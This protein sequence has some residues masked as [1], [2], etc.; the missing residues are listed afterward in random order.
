M[1]E[2]ILGIILT[3]GVISL[4]EL[5]KRS[6]FTKEEVSSTLLYLEKKGIFTFS[7]QSLSICDKCPLFKI[8]NIKDLKTKGGFYVNHLN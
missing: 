3:E 7:N 4:N 2:I 5:V 6:G 1:Y 8:C